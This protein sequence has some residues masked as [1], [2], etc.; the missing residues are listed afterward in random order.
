MSYAHKP[1]HPDTHT[2]TH[3]TLHSEIAKTKYFTLR[4][5]C[6]NYIWWPTVSHKFPLLFFLLKISIIWHF[7]FPCH[8]HPL[9]SSWHQE[10]LKL[11]SFAYILTWYPGYH[12][13]HSV[14]IKSFYISLH[15][16]VEGVYVQQ[17]LL[18]LVGPKLQKN[19]IYSLLSN[20]PQYFDKILLAR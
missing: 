6:K 16:T 18:R 13:I 12:P 14:S 20:C 10:I 2:H 19:T 11:L 8:L 15:F 3:I 1:P 7:S 5:S 17:R 9:S 4:W